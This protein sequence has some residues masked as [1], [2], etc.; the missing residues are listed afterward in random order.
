MIRPQALSRG[1]THGALPSRKTTL[2]AII[3]TL[4]VAMFCAMMALV[5]S[6]NCGTT[7]GT[8]YIH[9]PL[10]QPSGYC[11][12]TRLPGFPDTVQSALLVGAVYLTPVLVAAFAALEVTAFGGSPQSRVF[13]AS[14]W[15]AFLLIVVTLALSAGGFANVGYKGGC[16]PSSPSG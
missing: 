10:A 1:R 11:R 14:L 16:G 6:H 8:F 5:A 2:L 4:G 12:A 9:D 13:Q 7:D 15:I 3:G